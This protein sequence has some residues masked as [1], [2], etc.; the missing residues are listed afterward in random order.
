MA[1]LGESKEGRKQGRAKAGKAKA[2]KGE[3]K[4]LRFHCSVGE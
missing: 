4:S 1:I 2:R 3:M